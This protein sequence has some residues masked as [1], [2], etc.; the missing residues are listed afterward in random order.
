MAILKC[1]ECGYENEQ[2]RV[3]C[4]ECG[5]KLDRSS[6]PPEE[7]KAD[8]GEVHRRVKKMISPNRGVFVGF[9]RSSVV[10]LGCAAFA[11]VLI[12]MFRPAHDIPEMP[13]STFVDALPI[14]MILEQLVQNG[15]GRSL[16]LDDK[17]VNDYLYGV[18]RAKKDGILGEYAKYDR[19]FVNTREDVIEITVQ[20]SIYNFP[21]YATTF[22]KLDI[23]EQNGGLVTENCGGRFGSLPVHPVV[24]AYLEYPFKQLW[25]ATGRVKRVMDKLGAVRVDKGGVVVTAPKLPGG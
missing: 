2:E 7:E 11:A 12:Q 15:G 19:T 9:W 13:E 1:K 18:I 6:L 4:H 20:Y 21:V 23:D 10:T 24:M 17:S 14:P 22:Y 16:R 3:Y 25:N 8:P 5:V